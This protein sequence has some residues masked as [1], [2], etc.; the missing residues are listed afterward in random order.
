MEPV[1]QGQRGGDGGI[2]VLR[3][4]GRETGMNC[5]SG[6]VGWMDV[7]WGGSRDPTQTLQ[8][9]YYLTEHRSISSSLP[10]FHAGTT[11]PPSVSVDRIT[12][13]P[14]IYHP[15]SSPQTA[16][17]PPTPPD[18]SNPVASGNLGVVRWGWNKIQLQRNKHTPPSRYP[19][20]T[21]LKAFFAVLAIYRCLQNPRTRS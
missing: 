20:T 21:P 19:M 10:T 17:L 15:A 7:E 18:S 13:P 1:E 6:R 9:Y 14:W 11:L 8:A 16:T 5:M 2:I 4:R 3:W 12:I